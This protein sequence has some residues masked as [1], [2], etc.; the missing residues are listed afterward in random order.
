MTKSIDDFGEILQRDESLAPYTWLRLGGRAEYLLT[1][2]TEDQLLQ[3]ARC[4]LENEIPVRI[5]GGGSNVLV[6]DDGVRGAVIRI[7]EP[8]LSDVSVTG[9]SVTA[10]GGA[11]LSNAVSE[12]V[13][14]QLTGL[15]TLVG[16]PGTIGGALLGNSGSRHG[17]IGKLIRSVSVL[18]RQGDVVERTGD[19]LV[20]SY[21]QCSLDDV[22][23]LSAT[24]QLKSDPSDDLTL[25][26]RKNWIMKRATQPLAD[27]SAGCIFR[28]PRG[29][30]AGALIEQCGLKGMTS[31]QA[32]ISDRHANFIVTEKGA[33]CHDVDQLISRIRSAVSEKF[34]VEL[35]LEI[36]RWS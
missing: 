21:R 33:T 24:L 12:A 9:E 11:L 28:N 7:A 6:S 8:L 16:I 13:R 2:E 26:M 32:R 15:E 34:G 17:D 30:S 22:L 19:E 18:N 31:G 36:C 20:F 25:R 1:P 5:L 23:V 4:C 3:V 14:A 35:E 27:Q 29:L 10:G